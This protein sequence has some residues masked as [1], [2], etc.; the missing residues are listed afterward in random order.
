MTV[1][2]ALARN[3]SQAQHYASGHPERPDRVLAILRRIASDPALRDIPWLEPDRGNAE[4]ALLVHEPEMVLAVQEMSRRGGGWFDADTYCNGESYAVALDAAACAA[5]AAR[6]VMS[7]E[8]VSAFAV[9]RPPGHHATADRPMGFCLFNNA[10]VAVRVAQLAGAR[11]VAVV[12]VDVH[13]GNGTQAIFDDDRSVLYCSLHQYPFWPGT[14]AAGEHGGVNAPGCT[15]NVPLDAGTDGATWLS[16]FDEL[17]TPAVDNFEPDLILVSAGYDAHARDPLAE[18]LLDD[19]AYAAI[20]ERVVALAARNTGGRSVW[21]LEGGYDL[22]ALSAS[23]AAQL[24]VL[25]AVR[26]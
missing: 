20:A 15:L 17:V 14:G 8:A 19:A 10:A 16:R 11:R 26:V 6:A 5:R 1:P 25:S 4:L 22:D 9:V 21:L 7:D 23:V 12:D 3:S 2:L 18:L 13:H 24:S